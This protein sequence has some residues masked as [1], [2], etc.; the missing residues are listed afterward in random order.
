MLRV[1]VASARSLPCVY[2][3]IFAQATADAVIK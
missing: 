3:W 1:R 2:V